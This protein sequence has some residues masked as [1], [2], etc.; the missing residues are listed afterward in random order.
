MTK[1]LN[2]LGMLLFLTL[3]YSCGLKDVDDVTQN[4]SDTICVGTYNL[5]IITPVDSGP[6]SWVNRRHYIASIIHHAAFQLIGFQEIFNNDQLNDMKQRL[7][8]YA[9]ITNGQ[10]NSSGTKGE[11]LAIAYDKYRFQ[12]LE[13]GFFFLSPTPNFPGIGWDA[14]TNRIC[15]WARIYDLFNQNEFY[16]FNTHFNWSGNVSRADGAKLVTQM[17]DSL[18][19]GVP[20]ICVGDFNASTTEAAFYNQM[21]SVLT[22]SRIA[23]VSIPIG[24]YGTYNCWDT[25]KAALKKDKRIDYVFVKD[26]EVL[27]YETLNEKFVVDTWP[28][29]HFPVK[30]TL[31]MNKQV[32]LYPVL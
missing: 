25:S 5:R 27:S 13:S 7:L 26:F 11:M 10:D 29:D 16:F 15:Q 6:R 22:D 18:A 32:Q 20:V 14:S 23:T 31:I 17:I 4:N 2:I 21:T 28:S 1:R 8:N 24:S 12:V 9:F 3:C 19:V 30:V